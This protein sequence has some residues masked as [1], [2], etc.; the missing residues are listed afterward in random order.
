MASFLTLLFPLL[1][2]IAVGPK[3]VVK[4]APDLTYISAICGHETDD[5]PPELSDRAFEVTGWAVNLASPD[6][7]GYCSVIKDEP[8]MYAYAAC[9]NV[10]SKEDCTAC[11]KFAQNWLLNTLCKDVY[12]GQITL[13]G[14]FLRYET[15]KFCDA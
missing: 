10:V 9:P 13:A 1:A 4:A 7:F 5:N 8:V 14:C 11:L 6:D 3:P 15:H 2:I 12:G